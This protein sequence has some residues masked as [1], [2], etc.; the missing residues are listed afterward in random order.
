MMMSASEISPS[1]SE[2][3]RTQPRTL[4]DCHGQVSWAQLEATVDVFG[5]EYVRNH[6]AASDCLLEGDMQVLELEPGLLLYRTQ[7]VDQ[8]DIRTSNVLHPSLKLLVLLSGRMQVRYGT[9]WIELDAS[10]QPRGL[11]VNLTRA[12]I[13]MRQW[14]RGRD[15]R[16]L[17]ISCSPDWLRSKG[18][19]QSLGFLQQHLALRRWQPSR[20]AIVLAQQ[21]HHCDNPSA[22]Q[23]LLWQAKAQ[24]MLVEALGS[25]AM[26]QP[27]GVEAESASGLSVQAYRTLVALRDWLATPQ[28]DGLGLAQIAQHAGLS[29]SYLRR[30]FA[31]V[32]H[33]QSVVEFVRSQRL[34]RAGVALEREGISVARAADIAGYASVTHFAKAFRQAFGCAPSQWRSGA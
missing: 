30:H 15:E 1:G 22:L 8:C 26:A 7:V 18:L 14:Q 31:S 10:Q 27:D 9:Q 33:G 5:S 3:A 20:K 12:D 11:L 16:K 4:M 13:F 28:S 6:A 25:W 19:S 24:T 21:L 2:I 23:C 29:A 34:R 17:L 32:A